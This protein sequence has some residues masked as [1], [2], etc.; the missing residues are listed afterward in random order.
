ME[1]FETYQIFN[2]TSGCMEYSINQFKL[3]KS[4]SHESLVVYQIFIEY[5]FATSPE[6]NVKT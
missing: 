5:I 1:K 3:L 4:H 6:L 2:D